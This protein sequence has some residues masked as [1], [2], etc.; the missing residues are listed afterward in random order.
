MKKQTVKIGKKT[1]KYDEKQTAIGIKHEPVPYANELFVPNLLGDDQHT[2]ILLLDSGKEVDLLFDNQ[3]YKRTEFTIYSLKHQSNYRWRCTDNNLNK[4]IGALGS[5]R[6]KWYKA[7]V[8]LKREVWEKDGKI[9][10]YF[11][12]VNAGIIKL[13]EEKA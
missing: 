6:R 10:T 5:D 2:E 8:T 13:D 1:F 4:I 3:P 9:I 11:K 7:K 12:V